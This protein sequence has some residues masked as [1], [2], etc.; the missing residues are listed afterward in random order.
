MSPPHVINLNSF[1]N[2]NYYLRVTEKRDGSSIIS[3]KI[4]YFIFNPLFNISYP[5][6]KA[7][8]IFPFP[9]TYASYAKYYLSL[10]S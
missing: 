10:C 7:K 2:Q 6:A 8:K 5:K 1:K 4:K 9:G 3:I